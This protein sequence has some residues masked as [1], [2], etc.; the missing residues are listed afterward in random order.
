MD[1]DLRNVSLEG[2]IGADLGDAYLRDVDL[3]DDDVTDMNE[4]ETRP[5]PSGN[6]YY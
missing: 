3:P 4:V 5:K 6:H 2:V 1:A